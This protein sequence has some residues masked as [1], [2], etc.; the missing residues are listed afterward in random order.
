M[1]T[2]DCYWELENIGLPTVEFDYSLDDHF[3]KE[4]IEMGLQG[5]KY[6]VAK[7]PCG[8]TECLTKLQE[9][10]FHVIETQFHFLKEEKEFNYDDKLVKLAARNLIFKRATTEEELNVVLGNMTADMFTTDRVYLDPKLG[11]ELGLRR[12]KNWMRT[13]FHNGATLITIWKGDEVIGYNIVNEKEYWID[14][15]LG[16]MFKKYQKGYG[17][18]LASSVFFYFKALNRPFKFFRAAVSSNNTPN[19]KLYN[20]LNA[21][22]EQLTYVLVKHID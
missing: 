14:G 6:A 8:N 1:K 12:Y 20:Y 13:A 19:I 7:V 21:K 4:Q 9:L 22:I 11:P 3:D 5:Y 2:V 16:G 10:G 17:F 18:V 15:L